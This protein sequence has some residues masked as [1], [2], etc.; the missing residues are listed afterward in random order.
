MRAPDFHVASDCAR[1]SS[2]ATAAIAYDVGLTGRL[3][4]PGENHIDGGDNDAES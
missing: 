2:G 3:A 1:L 4:I